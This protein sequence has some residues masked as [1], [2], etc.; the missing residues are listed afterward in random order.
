MTDIL[1]NDKLKNDVATLRDSKANHRNKIETSIAYINHN[2]EDIKLINEVEGFKDGLRLINYIDRKYD[3]DLSKDDIVI[4]HIDKL[5]F[6]SKYY[7]ETPLAIMITFAILY[8]HHFIISFVVLTFTP[9][10]FGILWFI[11]PLFLATI[12]TI[13]NVYEKESK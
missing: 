9:L 4:K 2:I 5:L 6:T 10:D 12:H 13:V 8:I 7:L 1:N 3:L 11:I